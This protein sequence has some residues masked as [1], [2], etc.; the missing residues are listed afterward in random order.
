MHVTPLTHESALNRHEHVLFGMGCLDPVLNQCWTTL[1][2]V[3]SRKPSHKGL[4]AAMATTGQGTLMA[5][6]LGMALSCLTPNSD[7]YTNISVQE[8][9]TFVFGERHH[10]TALAPG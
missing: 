3:V 9:A 7:M 8:L 5:Q 10:T 4:V 1:V 2:N 6:G